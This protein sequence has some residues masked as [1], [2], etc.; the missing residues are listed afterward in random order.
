MIIKPTS[1]NILEEIVQYKKKEVTRAKLLIPVCEL[2]QMKYFNR[3]TLKLTDFL[4]DPEKTGIITEFKR[5]SPSKGIINKSSSVEEVTTGYASAGASAL[6]ILTDF[7]FFGGSVD[8]LMKARKINDIPI[9]RK[10]FIIDE[11]Q[12]YEA[13]AIGADAI[14]LIAVILEKQQARMLASKAHELGLQ[15]LLE[16]HE[17]SELDILN[18]H[19]DLIGI[20]N[21]NLKTFVVNLEQSVKLAEKI[22]DEFLKV[23]ESGIDS[24]EDIIFL[25]QHGFDGFLIGES[26]MKSKNPAEAFAAFVESLKTRLVK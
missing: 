15:T 11:Y 5:K 21:R 7:N 26:F 9:L 18:E 25:I 4:R 19:I 6:S 12:V 14:L 13:K 17:E 10:E 23:S 22:P 1:M 2:E 3:Q 8:D 16:L 20:N 24:P